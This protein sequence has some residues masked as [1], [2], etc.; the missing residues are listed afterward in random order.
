MSVTS[1]DQLRHYLNNFVSPYAEETEFIASFRDLLQ[2]QRCYF[3][4]HLPGHITGSAWIVNTKKDSA[5]LVHH[6]KLNRWLQPGGHADG[7][8]NILNVA[9]REANEETGLHKLMLLH[10]GLFDIDIHTI[11]ARK[12][13]PAHL[14]YDVRFA[15]LADD[16]EPLFLSAESHTLEWIKFSDLITVTENNTSIIRMAEKSKRLP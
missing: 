1:R 14:H 9:L 6:R 3:R 15:L 8:E 4:D 2:S 10:E 12:D 16:E 5:L 7:D 13:F 11:P